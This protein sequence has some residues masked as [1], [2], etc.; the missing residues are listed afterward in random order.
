MRRNAISTTTRY[1]KNVALH[2]RMIVKRKETIAEA[3]TRLRRDYEKLVH[4][5]VGPGEKAQQHK[6]AARLAEK[7]RQYYNA[8]KYGK[9]EECF[10]QAILT[11]PQY[12]LP[13]TY[14]GHTLHKMGKFVEAEAAWKRAHGLDP[15]CEAGLDALRKLQHLSHQRAQVVETLE[16]RI[17]R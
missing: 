17:E 12:V 15:T 2:L 8:G 6:S 11:D 1:L 10:R 9:A 16:A 4:H 5:V 13:M 3:K 14:L 7:G